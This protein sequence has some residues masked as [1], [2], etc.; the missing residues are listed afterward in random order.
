MS[1]SRYDGFPQVFLSGDKAKA[2]AHLGRAKSLLSEVQRV[3]KVMGVKAH[4]KTIGGQGVEITAKSIGEL[5]AIYVHVAEHEMR[6]EE[7]FRPYKYPVVLSGYVEAAYIN[8]SRPDMAFVEME[9]MRKA[10]RVTAQAAEQGREVTE[11]ELL[12]TAEE[13]ELARFPTGLF[14]PTQAT[15]AAYGQDYLE[16]QQ[17]VPF[18]SNALCAEAY[19]FYGGYSLG[20]STEAGSQLKYRA[21][22][23]VRPTLLTGALAECMQCVLGLHRDSIEALYQAPEFL[24][25]GEL[26]DYVLRYPYIKF[27]RPAYIEQVV[28]GNGFISE[29]KNS[30]AESTGLVQGVDFWWLVEVRTDRILA[31]PLPVF[32]GSNLK[33]FRAH[34]KN[35]GLDALHDFIAK[36]KGLPT[37]EGI[38]T[39]TALAEA[40]ENGQ[41][42]DITPDNMPF[43][44]W[45]ALYETCGW[46]FSP[47]GAEAHNTGMRYAPASGDLG[48]AYESRWATLYFQEVYR[49][50]TRRLTAQPRINRTNR[51]YRPPY[52]QKGNLV[53]DLPIKVPYRFTE[54]VVSVMVPTSD[55]NRQGTSRDEKFDAVVWAGYVGGSLHTISYAFNGLRS[56]KSSSYG[57]APP[58][59]PYGGA[60]EWGS[61]AGADILP[62]V[63]FTNQWDPRQPLDGSESKNVLISRKLGE[64]VTGGNFF[65]DVEWSYYYPYAVYH[66]T[67]K[68]WTYGADSLSARIVVH[69]DRSFY[70]AVSSHVKSEQHK[71]VERHYTEIVR[72][73]WAG[74]GFRCL[75][76]INMNAAPSCIGA[77]SAEDVMSICN[78]RCNFFAAGI[79]SDT[80]NRH[81][82]HSLDNSPC[83]D[84]V[85]MEAPERCSDV[86]RFL[87]GT[88]P[89][90]TVPAGRT[91]DSI[92]RTYSTEGVA[93]NPAA[94]FGY[95][96]PAPLNDIMGGTVVGSMSPNPWLGFNNEAASSRNVNGYR[97]CSFTK[98]LSGAL[99]YATI[100][101]LHTG[102]MDEQPFITFVG[103]LEDG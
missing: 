86:D 94:E 46:S 33:Q 18:K 7:E 92:V 55:G 91:D 45:G 77:R 35:L 24:L 31:R 51:L 102:I 21:Y 74:F 99:G 38:P 17:V 53:Q 76:R 98:H 93:Y 101:R 13:L 62:P 75:A 78:Q 39:G 41:V 19:G 22:R 103:V 84:Y 64:F 23:Y 65:P 50:G 85:D 9:Q 42:F 4:A 10:A 54:E 44:G 79:H 29:Y 48:D 3:R 72:G 36:F 73:K 16:Q 66:Q 43:E 49:D 60:W 67:E 81:V 11:E 80:T 70:S 89:K 52:F 28:N 87:S 82:C 32:V 97:Y 6:R 96:F 27:A 68:T 30:W 8:N 57:E 2:L 37:G 26:E 71:Y 83:R 95:G 59:C 56:S 90:Y 100:G 5:N 40:L 12:L 15:V 34:Y 88:P 1:E 25:E 61:I 63:M 69:T 14:A 58:A 47:T 20:R